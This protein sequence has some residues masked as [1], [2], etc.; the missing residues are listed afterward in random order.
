MRERERE[1]DLSFYKMDRICEKES[2]HITHG[3]EGTYHYLVN[4]LKGILISVSKQYRST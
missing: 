4:T 3:E 2:G 1:R